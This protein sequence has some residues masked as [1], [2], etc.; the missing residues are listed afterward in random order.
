MAGKAHD[1]T[2]PTDQERVIVGRIGR[3]H[4]TRRERMGCLGHLLPFACTANAVAFGISTNSTDQRDKSG[5]EQSKKE[6][7]PK[8]WMPLHQEGFPKT[9]HHDEIG[10]EKELG[11]VPFPGR[12][13]NHRTGDKDDCRG[14]E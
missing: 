14:K 5:K 2:M 10:P 4:G 13:F 9:E 8:E 11:V 12:E 7:G 1:H 6:R 3:E